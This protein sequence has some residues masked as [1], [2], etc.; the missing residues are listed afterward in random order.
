MSDSASNTPVRHESV[1]LSD[2]RAFHV[3]RAGSAGP[4]IVFLHG[5]ID[6][7]R[8][9]E[10]MFASLSD[11]FALLAPD[12]RG[13][14]QT[15]V[16]REYSVADFTT[17]AIELIELLADE[18]VHLVGHSLGAIIAQ[19]LAEA[20]PDLLRSVVLIGGAVTARD[21]VALTALAAGL[22]TLD[23]PIPYEF[24]Y[25]FQKSTA[26]QPLSAAV[27]DGFVQESLKV[28][29][30]AWKA[31]LQGLVTDPYQPAQTPPIVP[32]LIVW[33]A[34]D[35]LFPLPDQEILRR[36]FPHA[37]L[38]DFPDNGHAPQW[39]DPSGVAAAV[40]AFIDQ[41]GT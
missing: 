33:G 35:E 13:H 6:S 36:R 30:H 14:G 5:Y 7:W 2:G 25:D 24:A 15:A 20:R 29:A 32:T 23:D 22:Q 4:P 10:R 17:D 40:R 28:R 39:E 8:S 34:H 38:V 11:R 41:P 9:F 16:T 37:R 26:F 18:P 1:R 3:V 31:A 21:N 19:R 12:Q 27:L